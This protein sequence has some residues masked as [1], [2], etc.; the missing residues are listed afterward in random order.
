M[1]IAFDLDGVLT[2]KDTI[3]EKEFNNMTAFD[4]DLHYSRQKP[5]KR[6]I[7]KCNSLYNCRNTIYIYTC[8]DY[9]FYKVT[10]DWLSLHNI[11]YDYIVMNKPYYDVLYDDKAREV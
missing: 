7:N 11:K 9:R 1:I 10:L 3:S 6:N 2:Q 5:N 8:R 4:L